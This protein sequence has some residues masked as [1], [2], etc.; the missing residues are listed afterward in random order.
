MNRLVTGLILVFVG[1]SLLVNLLPL[2]QVGGDGPL[3]AG[4]GRRKSLVL[5]A[6]FLVVFLLFILPAFMA[7]DPRQRR[8]APWT[9]VTAYLVFFAA[10]PLTF[11]A[12]I[13]GVH[14]RGLLCVGGLCAAAGGAALA[15]RRLFPGRGCRASW[16]LGALT[17]F[18]L[19]ALALYLESLGRPVPGW[20]AEASPMVW[21]HRLGARQLQPPPLPFLVLPAVLW[22]AGLLP[23][24]GSRGRSRTAALAVVCSLAAP[25]AVR[26][27]EAAGDGMQAQAQ[28]V[29]LAGGVARAGYRTPLEVTL[30]ARRGTAVVRVGSWAARIPADGRSHTVLALPGP[31]DHEVVIQG[32]GL[33]QVHPLPVELVSGEVTLV[34]RLDP[35][36]RSLGTG[37]AEV[38]VVRLDPG[39]RP[40][41]PGALEA[42]DVVVVGADQAEGRA[43]LFRDAALGRTLVI[44]GPAGVPLARRAHGLGLILRGD[45]AASP[46]WLSELPERPPAA[47]DPG[48]VRS[49]AH[50]DW[51]EMDLAPVMIFAGVYHLAFLLAFLLPLTLDSRKALGVYLAS[52]GFVVVVVGV[53]AFHV[54]DTIFLKDN[55]V[56]TQS[57]AL[58]VDPPEGEPL[59]VTRQILCFASLSQETRDLSFAP[60]ADLLAYR[61]APAR[62][63]GAWGRAGGRRVLHGVLLDR[64]LH[65]RVVRRD[66]VGP[67]VLDV[68]ADPG[69]PGAYRLEARP[70]VPDPLGLRAAE[71]REAV[72]VKASGWTRALEPAG[73]DRLVPV[74]G[75]RGRLTHEAFVRYLLGH[76]TQPRRPFL[77]VRFTGLRRPDDPQRYLGVRDLGA[78][79]LVPLPEA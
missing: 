76:F 9:A 18:V 36:T 77:L 59:T 6:G 72:L 52:V 24:R 38:R 15:C 39:R 16:T 19:P 2:V 12:Y 21:I 60:G 31:D 46:A 41:L 73:P 8:M 29:S 49:F 61:P 71:P 53:L 68:Y 54:L 3:V 1:L 55:Q 7:R 78:Y 56:Y 26:A 13:S 11:T 42:F 4:L 50:P 14:V 33:A 74:Q 34:A 45:P 40:R 64:R 17:C 20:L 75:G 69:R 47:V 10:L 25:G 67:R 66:H 48:L 65:K 43:D 58:L 37:S 30:P 62:S 70:G 51:E 22:G 32:A 27:P 28:V 57:I 44:L 63:P 23:R 35:G 5:Y 79:L